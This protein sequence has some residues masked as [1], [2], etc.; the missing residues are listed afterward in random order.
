[1]ILG[2][3]AMMAGDHA[4][5]A[6]NLEPAIAYGA[7]TEVLRHAFLASLASLWLGDD[8][9]ASALVGR[10]I[11]LARARGEVGEL[12][13]A[14]SGRSAQLIIAQRNDEAEVA[15]HEAAALAR[16]LSAENILLLLHAVL[17][18]IAAIQGATRNPTATARR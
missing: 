15:A 2:F 14:L 11:R 1:M 13:V 3:A 7:L 17:A 18:I 6:R 16:E 12:A 9:A 8:E 10:A 5:A 4:E